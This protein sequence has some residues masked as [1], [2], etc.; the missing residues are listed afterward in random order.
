MSKAI[1]GGRKKLMYNSTNLIKISYYLKKTRNPEIKLMYILLRLSGEGKIINPSYKH[2]FSV[3][4]ENLESYLAA[5]ERYIEVVNPLID[6]WKKGSVCDLVDY[7]GLDA[8]SSIANIAKIY[9]NRE[10][11]PIEALIKDFDLYK[12]GLDAHIF[13]RR[14]T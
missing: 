9:I 12:F 7:F 5:M 11:A 4:L 10:P 6:V 14:K 8:K 1:G 13:R 3:G 2:A